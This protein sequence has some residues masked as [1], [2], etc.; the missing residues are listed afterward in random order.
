MHLF[1]IFNTNP[2]IIVIMETILRLANLL[3]LQ[4]G[5]V[6]KIQIVIKA[7]KAKTSVDR[8]CNNDRDFLND[9]NLLY[10]LKATLQ[11]HNVTSVL[12][13]P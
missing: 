3:K 12:L 1:L 9:H 5:N 2:L 11:Q 10:Q 6:D 8:G 7:I 4:N 13:Q